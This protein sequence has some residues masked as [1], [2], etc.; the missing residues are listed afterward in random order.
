MYVLDGWVG[1]GAECEHNSG[2]LGELE[3]GR[4]L[5]QAPSSD[6][7]EATTHIADVEIMVHGV[8]SRVSVVRVSSR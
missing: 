5:F 3:M 1:G 7:L 6:N 2:G 4:R 8:V